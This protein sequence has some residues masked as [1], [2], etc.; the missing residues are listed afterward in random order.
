MSLLFFNIERNTIHFLNMEQPQ[1][2]PEEII[3][4]LVAED[5]NRELKM[6]GLSRKINGVFE[7][8]PEENKEPIFFTDK[9]QTDIKTE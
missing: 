6:I 7:I 4:I 2:L 1:S 5:P 3:T 8:D 9:P